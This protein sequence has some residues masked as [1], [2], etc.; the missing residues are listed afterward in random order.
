MKDLKW[1][2]AA[3]IALSLAIAGAVLAYCVLGGN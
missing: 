1:V 3:L 2:D